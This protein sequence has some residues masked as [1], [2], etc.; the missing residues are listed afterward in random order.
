MRDRAADRRP[1][2]GPVTALLVAA[3]ALGG[4]GGSAGPARAFE[5][6][7][8]AARAA[9]AFEVTAGELHALVQ[10][11]LSDGSALAQLR[12]VDAVDGRPADLGRALAGASGHDLGARLRALDPG[13]YV[14]VARRTPGGVGDP[15]AQARRILEE[16]RFQPASLP[17]PFRGLFRTLGRWL[18]P[19][20]RPLGRAW[21]HLFGHAWSAGL[22]GSATVILAALVSVRMIRRRSS[23][24][25]VRSHRERW[26]GRAEDPDELERRAAGAEGAGDLA[27]AVRLR[28]RAGLLRLDRAGVVVD[29]P[30]LTTGALTRQ[31]PSIRL[32]ELAVA[33]EE[34]AYGGR[35]ASADDVAAARAGWASVLEEVTR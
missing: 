22:I 9:S 13:P 35:P 33:F 31:L 11:A 10:R 25:V 26:R 7:A 28:F 12:R 3:L 16:R 15:G 27:L 32:R 20:S 23:A 34:V 21:R 29:R 30:S 6:T 19:A 4:A 1:R 2:A 14:G 18:R 17:R 24:G 8:G 5:V